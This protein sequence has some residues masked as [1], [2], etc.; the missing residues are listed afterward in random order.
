MI[1]AVGA[2]IGPNG[3]TGALFSDLDYGTG[4]NTGNNNTTLTKGY[5]D[6]QMKKKYDNVSGTRAAEI[7]AARISLAFSMAR[8]ADPSGRLSNQDIELQ[9]VKLGGDWTQARYAIKAIDVAMEEFIINK[10]KFDMIVKYGKGTGAADMKDFKVID[11]VIAVDTLRKGAAKHNLVVGEVNSN[12]KQVYSLDQEY[13][14]KDGDVRRRYIT[15]KRP[16]T[17][18]KNGNPTKIRDRVTGKEL[19][20]KLFQGKI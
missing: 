1:N 5:I 15:I 3:L 7:N 17:L 4:D 18:D 14:T 2:I 10:N 12:E 19:D 9:M 8:A 20:I 13:T 6:A 16:N 11:A